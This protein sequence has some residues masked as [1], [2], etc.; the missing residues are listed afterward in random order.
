[1]GYGLW[2]MGNGLWVMGERWGVRREESGVRGLG[3]LNFSLTQG[4]NQTA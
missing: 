1:M 4:I 2:V 3:A